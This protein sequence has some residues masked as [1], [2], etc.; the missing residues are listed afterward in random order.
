MGAQRRIWCHGT[1][2]GVR[3]GEAEWARADGVVEAAATLRLRGQSNL[4]GWELENA[5]D[6]VQE[7]GRPEA[8]CLG[9]SVGPVSKHPGMDARV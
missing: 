1:G 6:Y 4:Y 5:P 3:G 9:Q 8:G 2:C 7:L